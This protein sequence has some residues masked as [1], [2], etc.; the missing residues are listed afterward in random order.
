MEAAA[1]V[2]EKQG[3]KKKQPSINWRELGLETL[4]IV[5]VA[6]IHGVVGTLAARSVTVA[7][8]RRGSDNIL[9]LK[10]TV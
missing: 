2:N 1:S 7:F 8:Q 5:G 10:R 3:N 6:A 4:K 9:P